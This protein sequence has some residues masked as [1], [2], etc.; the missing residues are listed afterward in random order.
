MQ[1]AFKGQRP[2]EFA[3]GQRALKR[4]VSGGGQMVGK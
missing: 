3:W 4:E 1:V 2:E